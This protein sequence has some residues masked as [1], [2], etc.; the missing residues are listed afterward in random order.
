MSLKV[1]RRIME[2]PGCAKKAA[3]ALLVA[4]ANRANDDGTG[5]WEYGWVRYPVYPWIDPSA[6]ILMAPSLSHSS[7]KPLRSP[8]ASAFE[9]PPGDQADISN[10]VKRNPS[11]FM[12][13]LQIEKA[14][15]VAV[16]NDGSCDT[17]RNIGLPTPT[18]RFQPLFFG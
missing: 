17:A 15:G 16:G 12:R 10:D 3:W 14:R 11:G 2:S 18:Q 13:K 1:I 6:Q 4:M 5:I 9:R 7:P 8:P